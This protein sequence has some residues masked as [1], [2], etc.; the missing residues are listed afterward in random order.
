MSNSNGPRAKT[1]RERKTRTWVVVGLIA[2]AA[3][4]ASVMPA[5]AMTTS[6]GGD[7]EVGAPPGGV[8]GPDVRA[9]APDGTRITGFSVSPHGFAHERAV[10]KRLS[11]ADGGVSTQSGIN[12]T[13][14]STGARLR[15]SVPNG[16]VLALAYPNYTA[17]VGCKISGSDGFAWGYLDVETP[18]GWRTGWMRQDLWY[19][20]QF[21]G[22]GNG[23]NGLPKV[24]WC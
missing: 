9:I 15:A 3:S 1:T 21:T 7:T 2:A 16:A 18:Q 20:T 6:S 19:V 12:V 5:Y 11:A 17:F 24:P 10:A 23:G 22:P 4:V 14:A 8:A 13:I